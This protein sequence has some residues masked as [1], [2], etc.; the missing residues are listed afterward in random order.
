MD[1]KSFEPILI[2]FIVCSYYAFIMYSFLG[3]TVSNVF[4]GTISV[5]LLFTMLIIAFMFRHKIE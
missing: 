4:F 5:V 2:G 3:E 1:K